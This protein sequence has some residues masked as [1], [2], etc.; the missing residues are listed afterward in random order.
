SKPIR[1]II[2]FPPGSITD[3]MVRPLAHKLGEV[4]GQQ[5]IVD[6][7]PGATGTIAN[8]AVAKSPADGY[9]LLAAPGSSIASYPHL[10]LSMPYDSL[11]DITPVVLIHRFSY[12]L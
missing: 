5:I 7:R 3:I 9:T 6:N 12:V 4:L 11:K 1:M 8:E 10:R 2:G